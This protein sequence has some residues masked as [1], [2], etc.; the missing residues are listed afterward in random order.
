MQVSG[1]ELGNETS[2]FIHPNKIGAGPGHTELNQ[3]GPRPWRRISW[4]EGGRGRGAGIRTVIWTI[5]V[6]MLRAELYQL[7][8][9]PLCLESGKAP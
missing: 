9:D 6:Q 2:D 7:P 8:R 4:L 5:T 3:T 1:V